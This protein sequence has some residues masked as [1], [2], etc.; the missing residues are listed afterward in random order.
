MAADVAR[1]YGATRGQMAADVARDYGA[2]RDELVAQLYNVQ[3][4]RV[5]RNV[6]LTGCRTTVTTVQ[7]TTTRMVVAVSALAAL[8]VYTRGF[9]DAIA[10]N[11][12]PPLQRNG[13]SRG[14]PY[15]TRYGESTSPPSSSLQACGAFA[16]GVGAHACCRCRRRAR[17]RTTASSD[18]RRHLCQRQSAPPSSLRPIGKQPASRDVGTSSLRQRC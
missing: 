18:A 2:T 4:D 6:R 12:N 16:T 5:R 17:A 10:G 11:L 14:G 1:D 7:C 3:S 8:A 9:A 13:R 15:G